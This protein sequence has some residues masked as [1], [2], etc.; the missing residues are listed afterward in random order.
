MAKP[1][2]VR[3]S[4]LSTK[5]RAGAKPAR[6]PAASARR[7]EPVVADAGFTPESRTIYHGDV[8][9]WLKRFADHS[10]DACITDPPYNM[11]NRRGLGWAF[12]S[13]VTLDEDWDRYSR[14]GYIEFT[15]AWLQE[16]S[17]VVKPNGN[18]FVFGSYH[19]VY[20]IGHIVHELGL[21]VVN[22][23][24]WAKSNAQ[25]NITCRMF[26]E[27]T[28]QIIWVCNNEA[29]RAKNWTFNYRDMK[30]E[31]G[32]KQMRNVWTFPV[33]PRKEKANGCHPSQKPLTVLGRLVRAAT[34]PGELVLDCFAGSGST[35]LAAEMEG[36]DWVMV[37][38][39]ERYVSV[40]RERIRGIREAEDAVAW[41]LDPPVKVG[42]GATCTS[43]EPE[44]EPGRGRRKGASAASRKSKRRTAAKPRAKQRSASGAAN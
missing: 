19:N 13:H 26:T 28:E 5:S 22:S 34:N 17:R 40:C 7:S 44:K 37:E 25:P 43:E 3:S 4:E 10:V 18:I 29:K 14:E 35:A 42:L 20:D 6:R 12:S 41:P 23:L 2:T 33:T 8:I 36:R 27:S 15:R 11:S 32:G 39:D 9:A 16:V 30:E 24:V 31:N 21:R 38:K 1:R